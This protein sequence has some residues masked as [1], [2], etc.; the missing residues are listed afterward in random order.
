MSDT[1]DTALEDWR[2]VKQE[3]AE[4]TDSTVALRPASRRLLAEL[5]RPYRRWGAVLVV[6]VVLES[7]ARL[8][9]PVI[10]QRVLDDGIPALQGGQPS[11]LATL[12]G[13]MVGAIIVQVMVR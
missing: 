6:V 4:E 7:L 11:T 3:I 5:V 8:I 2:G 9:I 10:V 12:L 13:V 1:R